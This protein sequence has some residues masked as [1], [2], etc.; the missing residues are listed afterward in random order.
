MSRDI[1]ERQGDTVSQTIG[2]A[3][4]LVKQHQL[5]EALRLLEEALAEDFDN[6]EVVSSLKYLNFWKDRQEKVE[7]ISNRFERGEYLLSQ[8]KLFQDFLHRV[9]SASE[10]CLYV[11]RHHVFDTALQNYLAVYQN[12]TTRDSELLLRLGRC[13][14]WKGDYQ[15]ALEFLNKGASER[16]DSAEML[17]ELAD[18]YAMVNEVQR[19]KVF[20]RE[21]FF[22]DPQ[23][24]DLSNLE[25][26]LIHRLVESVV[27]MGIT[28]KA[29]NEW[30]PVYGVLFGV[31]TVKRE[32]RSIEYGKLKQSIYAL[33][34][35][36]EAAPNPGDRVTARLINRYFWLID[37]YVHTNEDSA[38]IDEVLLRLRGLNSQ[39]YRQY[40]N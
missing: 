17:A 22:V 7:E 15:T 35:E 38:K 26:G 21:A 33:E 8:W 16:P 9:G 10:R 19:A 4:E 18:C 13:H 12:G 14:K 36:H 28:G 27:E 32:L 1:S 37:H 11:I 29:V 24:V 5:G 23:G 34:R 40:V 25:S 30:V 2:R 6:S 3:Y 39:I 20:F 31:F